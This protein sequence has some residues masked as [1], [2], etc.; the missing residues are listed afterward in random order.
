VS[1]AKAS[2]APAKVRVGRRSIAIS[3]PEKVLFPD[4]GVTKMDLAEHY[5]RVGPVMLPYVRDRPVT[6]HVFPGGLDRPGV[7]IK[8][9][10]AHFPDWIPRVTVKKRDGETAMAIVREAAALV[11]LANQNCVTP[12]VWPARVDDLRRPDRLIFDFDP[13]EGTDFAD[14]QAAARATGDL[15][16]A[17]GLVPFAMTSGSRGL[18]VLTPI[19]RDVEWDEARAFADAVGER[20]AAEDPEHLTTAFR[21]AKRGGRIYVDTTRNAYAQH[22]VAPYAVRAKPGAPVA[23]PLEWDELSD[24]G[25]SSQSW[26]IRTI[27]DRLDS[28]GDPWKGMGRGA[29]SLGKAAQKL[30][31]GY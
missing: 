8:K 9:A 28:A 7:Y 12:H 6:M 5:A 21:I 18:H 4:S 25:L 30:A 22:G 14:V 19:R 2:E 24:P 23:T 16:R 15:L 17:V 29:R 11:F 1:P 27:G 13:P 3:H 26:N 31:G 10:P 20:L